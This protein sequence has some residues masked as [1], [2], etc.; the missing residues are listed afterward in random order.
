MLARIMSALA[1]RRAAAQ[2]AETLVW[3]FGSRGVAMARSRAEDATASEAQRAHC[4]RV[5]RIAARRHRALASLDTASR[6]AE[7][8]RW[9]GSAGAVHAKR[10]GAAPGAMLR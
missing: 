1:R 5:A 8:A 3:V 7:R 2:E 6:Y 4:R 9:Q 10:P